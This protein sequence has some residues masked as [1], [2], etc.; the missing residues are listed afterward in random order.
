M[1][2][3]AAAQVNDLLLRKFEIEFKEEYVFDFYD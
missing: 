2:F 1:S 3:L